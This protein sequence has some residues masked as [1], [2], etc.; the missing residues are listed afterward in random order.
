[1]TSQNGTEK[2]PDKGQVMRTELSALRYTW[3]RDAGN[4]VS[5]VRYLL[6]EGVVIYTFK[7][8]FR[9]K[10]LFYS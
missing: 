6:G 7:Y 1:M 5:E 10:S 2:K 3:C 4:A 9:H 8:T